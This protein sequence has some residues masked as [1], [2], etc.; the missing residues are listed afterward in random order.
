METNYQKLFDWT[1]IFILMNL[2]VRILNVNGEIQSTNQNTI[3]IYKYN[4]QN[5]KIIVPM[6]MLLYNF[7]R[8]GT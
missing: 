8:K 4:S 2:S 6:S 5:R 1:Q 7:R 3:K